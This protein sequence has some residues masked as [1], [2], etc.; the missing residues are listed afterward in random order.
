MDKTNVPKFY[1]D[2]NKPGLTLN[3]LNGYPIKSE[4]VHIIKRK[5]GVLLRYIKNELQNAGE[6]LPNIYDKIFNGN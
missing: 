4:Y 5:S 3:R 1:V 6:R 2:K